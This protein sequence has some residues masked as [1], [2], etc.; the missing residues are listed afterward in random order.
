[1]HVAERKSRVGHLREREAEHEK[2]SFVFTGSG[3]G[4][5]R[6]GDERSIKLS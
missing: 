5:R 1:M 3:L 4:S 6:H 2:S